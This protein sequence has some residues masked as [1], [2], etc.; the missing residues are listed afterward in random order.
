MAMRCAMGGRV[1]LSLA[2]P[3]GRLESIA[4]DVLR[5]V[6]KDATKDA[7]SALSHITPTM[8]AKMLQ[9]CVDGHP[10]DDA[11]N[12]PKFFAMHHGRAAAGV[13]ET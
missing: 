3:S 10:G 2:D 9:G 12:A 7:A 8:V 1:N 6:S 13:L 5:S 4:A 11:R